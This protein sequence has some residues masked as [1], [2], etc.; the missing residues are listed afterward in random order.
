M[1]IQGEEPFER[2]RRLNVELQGD[3]IVDVFKDFSTTPDFS[4]TLPSAAVAGGDFIWDNGSHIW[5]DGG[6]WDPPNSYRFA[7]VRPES[8]GR[9]HAIRFRNSPGGLPFLINVAEL[10]IRGG[11]EH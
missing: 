9:F 8:R 2:V 1:A 11:K 10:A 4:A 7:R 6:I 5:D 3:A